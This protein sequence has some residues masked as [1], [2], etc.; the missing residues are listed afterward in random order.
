MNI[1]GQTNR[2]L[3]ELQLFQHTQNEFESNVIYRKHVS[4]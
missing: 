2:D 3:H 1:H 4:G